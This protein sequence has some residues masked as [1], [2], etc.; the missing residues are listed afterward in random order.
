MFRLGSANPICS[1]SLLVALAVCWCSTSYAQ[2]SCGDYLYKRGSDAAM[3]DSDGIHSTG[4]EN[5]RDHVPAP[6]PIR[7]V[8]QPNQQQDELAERFELTGAAAR[9]PNLFRPTDELV[10]G[11]E[12]RDRIDRPPQS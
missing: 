7:S 12:H 10:A 2:A 6:L 11:D 1:R 5:C 8:P 9:L 4:E 3:N